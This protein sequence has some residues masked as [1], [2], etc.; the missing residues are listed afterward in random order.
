MLVLADE[1]L[2]RN[3]VFALD[4]ECVSQHRDGNFLVV[5]KFND[6]QLKQTRREGQ[7]CQ[8]AFPFSTVCVVFMLP[9]DLVQKVPRAS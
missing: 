6:F 8:H 4:A 2:L 5:G 9:Y 3:F 7:T 1:K